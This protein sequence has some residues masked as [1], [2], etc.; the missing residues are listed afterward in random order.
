MA[1]PASAPYT[2]AGLFP[3][4]FRSALGNLRRQPR[5]VAA[6]PVSGAHAAVVRG[7]G[8]E[9]A[10]H[11]PYTPGDDPRFVDWNAWA[12]FRHL[13][14]KRFTVEHDRP[15]AVL[16]DRSDSMAWGEPA[17]DRLGRQVAGALVSLAR[18]SHDRAGVWASGGAGDPGWV[19]GADRGGGEGSMGRVWQALATLPR[20]SEGRALAEEVAA[21]V[22]AAPGR[23]PLVWIT[24]AFGVDLEDGVRAVELLGRCRRPFSVV[25]I[26]TRDEQEGLEDGA[27]ELVEAESGATRKVTVDAAVRDRY[28]QAVVDYRERLV[29]TARRRG[30]VFLALAADLSPALALAQ[31]RQHDVLRDAVRAPGEG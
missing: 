22:R 29:T 19:A 13:I 15:L 31:L 17:K 28:R 4:E 21:W 18:A 16:L 11:R 26:T 1:N 30:G 20:R 3:P 24:D 10:D 5:A 12:R 8:L 27:F 25:Q 2:V 9:F 7:D 6:G 14:V 23:G